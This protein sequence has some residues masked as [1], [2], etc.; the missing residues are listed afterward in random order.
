MN[1][2]LPRPK[3]LAEFL[4]LPKFRSLPSRL[5]DPTERQSFRLLQPRVQLRLSFYVLG[6]SLGLA[7]L[8]VQQRG[9]LRAH[10]RRNPR[11]GQGS[12]L[13]EALE[14]LLAGDLDPALELDV[15]DA[16]RRQG[17]PE[18]LA[19]L[20]EWEAARADD[21]IRS[22]SFALEGGDAERGA[23][24]FQGHGDCLRCHG[25]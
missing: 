21:P 24:V 1:S 19:R 12:L 22:R 23:L 16:V 7:L 3:A 13:S 8:H 9:R 25:E 11:D 4:A 15:M 6:V 14:A 5:G 18:W 17:R 10:L 20:A 2:L